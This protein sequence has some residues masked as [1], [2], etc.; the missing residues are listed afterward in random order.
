[1]CANSTA[2]GLLCFGLVLTGSA[3]EG[4]LR[5]SVWLTDGES[6]PAGAEVVVVLEDV[7]VLD[8]AATMIAAKRFR[9]SSAP[10]YLFTLD[11]DPSVLQGR[12][13][14]SLRVRV[15]RDQRL[16]YV[17]TSIVDPFGDGELQ[18]PVSPVAANDAQ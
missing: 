12:R 1:M 6:L 10:P 11:Y 13:H 14:L 3:D 7:S 9:A 16:L 5:G 8:V 17:S 15:E 2:A 4:L 18:V